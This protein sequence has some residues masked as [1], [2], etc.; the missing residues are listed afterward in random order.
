[1]PDVL[2]EDP[3][4]EHPDQM[5]GIGS[6]SHAVQTTRATERIEPMLEAQTQHIDDLLNHSDS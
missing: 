6:A 2:L 3:G 1:M 4:A 5:L